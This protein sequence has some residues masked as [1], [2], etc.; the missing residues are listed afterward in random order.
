MTLSGMAPKPQATSVM[1]NVQNLPSVPQPPPRRHQLTQEYHPM[2]SPLVLEFRDTRDIPEKER[3][4]NQMAQNGSEAIGKQLLLLAKTTNDSD[5]RWLA[6]RGLGMLKF[7]PAAPFLVESLQSSERY[8]RANAARALG[9]LGYSAAAPALIHLLAVEQDGGVVEQTSLALMMTKTVAAIPTLESRMSH[10]ASETPQT[11]CW[12]LGAIGG[13]GSAN[14]LS[15]IAK[16]LDDS[17]AG[18]V[19][20]E[21]CAAH[22]MAALSGEDFGVQ[23]GSGLHDPMAPIS[24]A[25]QWWENPQNR[26]R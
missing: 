19:G 15:F 17:A 2:F 4:L 26:N 3:L 18:S 13:I 21:E 11:R 12:L 16:Y 24:K 22:A 20:V 8:V 1:V 14:D 10:G 23:N 5:T 7:R 25:R 6:I 9:E